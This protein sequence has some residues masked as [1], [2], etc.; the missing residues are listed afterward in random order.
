MSYSD[1]SPLLV[2]PDGVVPKDRYTSRAFAD[3][4]MERLWSRVWQVACRGGDS[5]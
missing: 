5:G 1:V 4:E 3:L 2:R